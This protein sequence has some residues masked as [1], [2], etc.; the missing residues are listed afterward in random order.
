MA[1]PA[2]TTPQPSPNT[3]H[4]SSTTLTRLAN[5]KNIKGVLLSPKALSILD[6]PLY[7]PVQQIPMDVTFK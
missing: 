5:I 3:N 7:K 6:T 2:P 4:K 1:T